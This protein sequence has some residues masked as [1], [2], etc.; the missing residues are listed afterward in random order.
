MKNNMPPK[1]KIMHITHGLGGIQTYLEYILRYSDKTNFE[2]IIVAPYNPAFQDFCAPFAKY[3]PLKVKREINPFA[4]IFL[5]VKL[6]RYIRKEKPDVLHV[7]S[8]KG[9]FLGRLAGKLCNTKVIYTPHGFSYLSFTGIK[10]LFYF[11]LECI[12]RNW[13]TVLLAVSHSEANRAGFEIG[14]QPGKVKVIM[15]SIYSNGQVVRRN[16][17]SGNRI[18]MIGRL[19]YQKNPM[20]FMDIADELLKKYPDLQFSILGAGLDDHLGTELNNFIN[21]KHLQGKINLLP[22]GNSST[23]K[24]FIEETD[25][26]VMTS[27]FEGLPFSLLEAMAGECVCV[28]SKA[29]GNTDVIQN[30]E[31]GFACLSKEEFCKNIEAL[32]LN[33]DLRVKF[34]KAGRKYIL[35][36]H[37]IHAA[38]MQLQNLY[39]NL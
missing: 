38:I 12:A 20:L 10:R 30:N 25:I 1:K 23:S 35:E 36:K 28:V 18:G 14:Y 16:Y 32:I 33:K 37:N 13:G 9:G 24:A 29:D 34:G 8:A 5:L 21:A 3:Y 2:Y 11:S 17:D 7:H 26:F 15:N 19:T 4:D 6:I 31:N 39:K 27:V 22:W